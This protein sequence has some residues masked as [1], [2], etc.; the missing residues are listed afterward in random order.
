MNF[1]KSQIL[2]PSAQG[3]FLM[4]P[5]HSVV[6]SLPLQKHG[7]GAAAPPSLSSTSS[8]NQEP[9]VGRRH[10]NSSVIGEEAPY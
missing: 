7:V 9:W 5:G 1:Q 8:A 4:C 6:S 10:T 3:H 2:Q